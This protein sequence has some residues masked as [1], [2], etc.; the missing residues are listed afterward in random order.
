MLRIAITPFCSLKIDT[1]LSILLLQS[2]L[3]SGLQ[4]LQVFFLKAVLVD[5]QVLP[6]VPVHWTSPGESDWQSTHLLRRKV[7]CG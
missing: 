2:L 1:V 4:G 5:R 6:A 7:R 3:C